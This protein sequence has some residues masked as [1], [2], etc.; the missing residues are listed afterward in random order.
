MADS[1]DTGQ[2]ESW[3]VDEV[4]EFMKMHFSEEIARKF[5]GKICRKI[6][7][8]C[9]FAKWRANISLSVAFNNLKLF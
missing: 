8:G 2:M 4:S 6:T 3:N 7:V 1:K 9:V 5:K